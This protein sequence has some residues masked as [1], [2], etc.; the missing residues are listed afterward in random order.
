MYV[1][2]GTYIATLLAEGNFFAARNILFI[3]INTHLF[4]FL[5]QKGA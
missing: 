2:A 3:V 5:E 1:V 4:R